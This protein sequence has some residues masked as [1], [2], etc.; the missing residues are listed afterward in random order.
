MGR[1]RNAEFKESGDALGAMVGEGVETDLAPGFPVERR[2]IVEGQRVALRLVATIYIEQQNR[3]TVAP[4]QGVF[5]RRPRATHFEIGIRGE[6]NRFWREKASG[7]VVTVTCVNAAP[8]VDDYCWPKGA[9]DF[10]HVVQDFVAPDFFGFFGSLGVAK[11]LCA[12]EKKFD[13]VAARGGQQLL[14]ADETELGSL[15]RA[16]IVLPALAACEGKERD[17]G[18]E[19]RAR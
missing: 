12:S 15:L 5:L 9:D 2:D 4:R 7:L 13:A 14:R 17:F 3:A 10:D 6:L 8:A 19:A 11:I 18:M 16:E 1:R